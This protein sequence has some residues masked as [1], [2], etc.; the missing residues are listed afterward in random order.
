[1]SFELVASPAAMDRALQ[2][3]DR[4]SQIAIDT[5]GN[6]FHAYRDSVCLIQ[7]ATAGADQEPRVFLVD[8]LSVDP[9]PL[10][11]LFAD[12]LHRLVVHGGDYD[13]RGLRRDFGFSFG[14]LFDTMLAAQT[15]HLKELGLAAL[16]RNELEITIAKA[17]QRSDW[18][19]RPLRA[20][21]LAYAAKDVHYLLRLAAR[22]EEKLVAADRLG[23]AEAQF[24]KLRHLK[25]REKQF[26]P[27]GWRRVKGAR[28]LNAAQSQV[29]KVLW[30]GRDRVC[31]EL[32]RAPFKLVAEP[33]MVDV[34][35]RSPQ[36]LE[37]LRKTPGVGA[38]LVQH[39]GSEI[40]AA[41]R[42][43]A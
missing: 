16:L 17:E 23:A 32:N 18:G 11:P 10:G 30:L 19:R 4:S 15:L 9:R 28:E 20:E 40:V 22:L 37:V 6:S 38:L 39:L 31:R 12:P 36:D 29:L 33:T 21:Q 8:P 34:A 5:E 24:E 3:L 26:D 25:A 14:R 13:V 42:G 2:W 1:M 43:Q 7:L 41:A 27:D 35:R